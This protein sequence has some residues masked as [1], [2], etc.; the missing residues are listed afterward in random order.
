MLSGPPFDGPH[1]GKGPEPGRTSLDLPQPIFPVLPPWPEF[2]PG[3]VK[4]C[5]P[6]FIPPPS[7]SPP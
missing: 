1:S 7:A 2:T 6:R 3:G 4:A 5:A